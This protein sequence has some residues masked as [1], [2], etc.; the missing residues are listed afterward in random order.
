MAGL[1]EVLRARFE[2]SPET[3]EWTA[4]SNP[5]SLDEATVEDWRSAGVNRLSVGVQSFDDNALGW[6][7]RLHDSRQATAA[8]ERG[9]GVGF[10][11]INLDLIFG[12]PDAIRRD[13]RTEVR[14][15]VEAGATH[16]SIYGLT[17]EAG[18]PLGRAVVRGDVRMA[19]E[20]RYAEEYLTAAEALV[21]A[22]FI[23]YEVSN[24]ALPGGECRHNWHYWDG[25]AYL[26]VGPSAH[27]LVDGTRVWN[28]RRWEAYRTTMV[29]GRSPREGFETTGAGESQL[30]RL[31]LAFRTNRGLRSA[32]PLAARV[33][34]ACVDL[35]AAWSAAG[36]LESGGDTL[37]MTPAGW[38]RLDELVAA[39]AARLEPG[40]DEQATRN[41]T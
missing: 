20:D 21:G 18:T 3:I 37:L 4:E 5:E 34:E 29:Q 30:E 15:A 17:A 10:K 32:D 16:V 28:V 26:G 27:S 36:W 40:L 24:F 22:G 33:R 14:M 38:L 19:G 2:W 39:L 9:R 7:G 35:L 6:L 41:D 8:V 23:H 25:S 12:L 31:W 11:N 1:A 13:W